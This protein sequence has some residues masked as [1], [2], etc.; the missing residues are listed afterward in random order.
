MSSDVNAKTKLAMISDFVFPHQNISML[1]QTQMYLTTSDKYAISQTL[2][3]RPKEH[4]DNALHLVH[5]PINSALF[6]QEISQYL[7]LSRM[8]EEKT[9]ALLHSL[10]WDR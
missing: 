3:L 2:T 4:N 8:T 7:L 9:S 6:P 1:T 5:S 10:V